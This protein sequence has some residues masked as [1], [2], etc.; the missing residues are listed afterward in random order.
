MN[1]PRMTS[2]ALGLMASA[3]ALATGLTCAEPLTV[4]RNTDLKSDRFL[5]APTLR[6]LSAG[7]TVD[8]IKIEA[9]WVQVK[10]AN[11]RGWV[12][13]LSL[14]G[15]STAA[16]ANVSSI[17]SG[18]S[19][20]QNAMST[21]GVRSAP[22]ASR[23]ALIIGIGEYQVN[24]ITPLKGVGKDMQSAASIA[25]AMSI[26]E[27]N[28]TFLRDKAATASEIRNAIEQLNSRVRSGDR[29]FVYYSGHGT[30]W[31]SATNSNQ[32]MEGLLA[33]D[34]QAIINTEV[35]ELLSPIAQKTDKLMV[36]YDACHSG[37]IANQPLRTRSINL[38]GTTLTPKFNGNVSPEVCA[39]PTNMRT[40][41]LST[42]L[43]SKGVLPENIVSIAAARPDEV[44]F[45]NPNSGGL[46]TVAWRDCLMGKAKDLDGSGSLSVDEITS[47]AQTQL[48]QTLTQYP[49]ILGQHMTIGG[50]RAFIPSFQTAALVTTDASTQPATEPV[51]PQVSTEVQA[52]AEPSLPQPST[53]PILP[54]NLLAQIH[55]QRDASRDITVTATPKVMRILQDPL[56]LRIQ[57]PRAGYLYVA[58]AGSDQKS[59][60]LLYPNQLDGNNQIQANQTIDLPKTGWRIT[61]AGPKGTD[62]VLVMVTD[63][64]RDVSQ[65]G[66]EK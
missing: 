47:C 14:K 65:L 62:T 43:H 60:Y 23:H 39:K 22:K 41:S 20:T 11:Q 13:A 40:R 1:T 44:S 35:G 31:M 38:A 37:G 33:S 24:G 48:N 8:S 36:F 16:I 28:I 61:A 17:E 59:L 26:P 2:P 25:K 27:E 45:D 3:L 64:A 9:G 7:Q 42:E 21:T 63:S 51:V 10:T 66:G 18:R 57:S 58:L 54:A 12:R 15:N 52:V 6:Q 29:V 56:Q 19:G 5:D 53:Q 55:A 49:D 30:R 50:N 4:L 32:C 46:A 34:G